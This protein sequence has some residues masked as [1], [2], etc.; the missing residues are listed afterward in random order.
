LLPEQ[1]F[2]AVAATQILISS[3]QAG[4]TLPLRLASRPHPAS[5]S[6]A[7]ELRP[8]I[9]AAPAVESSSR[10]AQNSVDVVAHLWEVHKSLGPRR[11][12]SKFC[13]LNVT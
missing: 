11:V 3:R 1:S 8:A 7:C 9:F 6:Q 5:I 4:I 2:A 13:A 12:P 10:P